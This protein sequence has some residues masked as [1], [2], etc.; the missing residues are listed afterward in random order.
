MTIRIR[1]IIAAVIQA[2]II[3]VICVFGY[4]S[5]NTVLSKLRAIEIIDD[6]NI[7]LLEIRKSEKNYF[8]YSDLN[9]LKEV[10]ERGEAI[11]QIVQSSKVDILKSLGPNTYF[12]LGNNLN[13]YLGLAQKVILSGKA[14]PKFE[15]QFR[16]LGHEL[17][18]LSEVLLK[19]ERR[20]VNNIIQHSVIMLVISLVAVL[21]F[22]LLV[23]Q[24]FFHFIIKELA[25]MGNMI[26]MASQGRL[27]EV[28]KQTISPKNEI[29][30]AIKALADM[31]R[32]LEKR[33]AVLL[34]SEK[35]ASLGILISGV[36]H[37]LGNP[38]NNIAL[39]AQGYLSL[40]DILG[41]A[42][43]KNFM[44]DVLTQTERISKIINNLLDFSRQKKQELIKY[45]PE[46]LI[47]KSIALVSNQLK[48][49]NV[50]LHKNIDP[51]LWPIYVDPPQI[52]QV[53]VNLYI[54]AIQAM[55]EGGDLTIDVGQDVANG[56]LIIRVI[57]TGGGISKE[58]LLHVFDPF[59]T[60]KGTKG[61]GL[62][63]SV[64]YGIMQQHHGDITVESEEGSGTTFT[65]KIP[66]YQTKEKEEDA[67]ADHNH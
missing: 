27:H 58:D 2:A 57:D 29:D 32:E 28:A 1:I 53:L 17:T 31:A 41:E 61:T 55:P 4:L 38:L 13:K 45:N 48:I 64:S 11:E 65:L 22:Q 26:Q 49:S 23:W 8:L 44:T 12:T 40:Y 35:L 54:N 30:D 37:E 34:Q 67:Q 33:E 66:I 19:R 46:S 6:L 63:L 24:Y 60:T 43:K 50:K 16:T 52:E 21:L 15:E 10:V 59:F 47:D 36:A 56:Y 25:I 5:F 7:S 14:P 51:N 62:G 3:C 42:E 9:A 20:D 39:M 18:R